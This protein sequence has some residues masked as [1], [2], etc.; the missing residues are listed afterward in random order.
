[1]AETFKELDLTQCSDREALGSVLSLDAFKAT[2]LPLS[3]HRAFHTLPYVP[4]PTTR[5][6]SYSSVMQADPDSDEQYTR[7]LFEGRLC[8]DT[9]YVPNCGT[10]GSSCGGA[11]FVPLCGVGDA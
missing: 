6:I 8:G 5:S 3:L 10:G 9:W 1:M 4:S 2:T 7:K 11:F